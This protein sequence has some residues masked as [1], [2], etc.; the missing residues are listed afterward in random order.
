MNDNQ[1]IIAE[2]KNL[3]EK[4]SATILAHNY[5]LPEIQDIADFV[6]DSLELARQA[7]KTSSQIIVLC[8][9][10]FMAETAKILNPN[11]TVL[12]PDPLSGCPL[13][14]SI[15]PAQL[16]QLIKTYPGRPVVA[17][18]NTSARVKAMSSICCTSANAPK[19]VKALPDDEIIFIPD[20]NLAYFVSQQTNKKIIFP[21]G[22]CIT[23]VK[24]TLEEVLK[25]K[26]LHPKAIFLA[27]P[28]CPPE[29]QKI[30]DVIA[31]TSQMLRY[32][33][34]S[35]AKEFIIATEMGLLHRL[36]KQNPDKKFYLA[37]PS[38]LCPNM[39]KNNLKKLLASLK[40]LTYE[41]KIPE[42]IRQKAYQA[43]EKM[44]ALTEK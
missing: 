32:A 17:Y 41:I 35:P 1:E 21:K 8:G 29:I 24:L 38:L 40:N 33:Q 30:A 25:V 10:Y 34:N 42:D 28:E 16:S 13:A 11:R 9:V 2:I 39:K 12:I 36:Q 37:S 18:V 19:V 22:F 20:C 14:D 31:S 6:G 23:H 44:F 4:L 43:I 26:E 15:D 5:Q 7:Q 3:K 27:H